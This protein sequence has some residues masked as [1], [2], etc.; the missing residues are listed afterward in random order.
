[1]KVKIFYIP[2]NAHQ[3]ASLIL[4]NKHYK[5]CDSDTRIPK[6]KQWLKIRDEWIK[7]QEEKYGKNKLVCAICNR[8][9]LHGFTK[10]KNKLATIDHILPKSE[11]PE[12][13]NVPS[14]FQIS[15]YHCNM[16]KGNSF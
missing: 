2:Q 15:C 12:L 8:K 10:D 6:W 7:L 14:N 13:W 16:K 1:M 4:L 3:F 11:F 5:K 9:N